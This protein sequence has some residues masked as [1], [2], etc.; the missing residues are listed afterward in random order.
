MIYFI[1]FHLLFSCENVVFHNF[2]SRAELG[3]VNERVA[4]PKLLGRSM[5]RAPLHPPYYLVLPSFT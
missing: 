3:V 2:P 4:R 1:L 5:F